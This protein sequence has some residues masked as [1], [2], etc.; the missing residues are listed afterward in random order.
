MQRM[1][2]NQWENC[3]HKQYRV[4]KG[5]R[6]SEMTQQVHEM[7]KYYNEVYLKTESESMEEAIDK[8]NVTGMEQF[9]KR[10]T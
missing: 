2:G 1:K 4:C 5:K 6:M 9:K 10:H 8:G 7:N 3:S